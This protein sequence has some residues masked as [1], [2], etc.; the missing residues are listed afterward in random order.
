VFVGDHGAGRFEPNSSFRA[1][2]GVGQPVEPTACA[3]TFA[4]A[5][6]IVV[7]SAGFAGSPTSAGRCS[8]KYVVAAPC[9]RKYAG[10]TV[11][12][13]ETTTPGR[14]KTSRTSLLSASA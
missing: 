9:A 10:N 6:G 11:P 1:I 14:A 7:G 3:A 4:A 2:H 12:L 13:E 5:A 8:T